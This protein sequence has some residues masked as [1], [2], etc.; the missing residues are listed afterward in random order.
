MNGM[1]LTHFHYWMNQCF[2]INLLNEW[3]KDKYIFNSPF[4]PPKKR[5]EKMRTQELIGVIKIFI[6]QVSD[7]GIEIDFRFPTLFKSLM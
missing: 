4:S 1:I 3:F 7:S 6:L 5:K 2:R